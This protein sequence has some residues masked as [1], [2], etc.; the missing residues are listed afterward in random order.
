[1]SGGTWYYE[2]NLIKFYFQIKLKAKDNFQNCLL[3]LIE[4][5]PTAFNLRGFAYDRL[6]ALYQPE[7]QSTNDKGKLFQSNYVSNDV[8]DGSVEIGITFDLRFPSAVYNWEIFY[9]IPILV[10]EFL[11]RHQRFDDAERWLS[12]LFDPTACTGESDKLKNVWQFLPFRDAGDNLEELFTAVAKLV[13]S[14]NL[15][16]TEESAVCAF[17]AQIQ[18]WLASP[19]SPFAVARA[20][21]TAFQWRTIFSYLDSLIARGDQMFRRFTRESVNEAVQYYVLASKLLGPRPQSIRPQNQDPDLSYR[22]IYGK[23]DEFSKAWYTITDAWP[24]QGETANAAST[25]GQTEALSALGMAYFCIP[26]NEKLLGYWDT[27]EDRLFKVRNCMDIDGVARELP[28]FAP[29]IDPELLVRAFAAGLD[30]DTILDDLYA[31]LLPYRF[32]VLL[33][34]AHEICAEV[35]SL[36]GALLAALE[37]KDAEELALLRSSQEI[38]ML[39]LMALIKEQQAKEAEANLDV[40]SQNMAVVLA[41]HNQYQKL[42]GKPAAT[43][44]QNGLPVLTSSSS[45]QAAANLPGEAA[46]L[47]L[48]QYE[49]DQLNSLSEANDYTTAAGISSTVASI[50]HSMPDFVSGNSM[51]LQVKIGGSH[52]G[53]AANAAASFLNM[54]A[55]RASHEATEKGL[56]AS[57][58]RRQDEWVFQ[59]RLALEEMKQINKQIIAAEIRLEIARREEQNHQKQIENARTVDEFMHRKYTNREL[60]SWM[61]GELATVYF[62]A[63]KLANDT[64]KRAEKAFQFEL[65]KE[66]GSFIQFGYWDSLK[67]GLLSGEKLSLDLKR[68][69]MAYLEQNRRELEISKHLS[70]LQLDPL[71]LIGLKETGTCEVSIPEALF[72]I[73][74]PGHYFRRIKSVSI[75]IPCV[76]GPYTSVSCT[77][78]LL[79]HS[80]RKTAQVGSDG[81]PRKTN[82]GG[83]PADDSRFTDSFG[84]IQSIATSH[85]QNDS[86]MFELNFRDERYLPFEGAGAISTW[87]IG[88]PKKFRQFDYDTISDAIIHL[89][90]TA[91]DGGDVLAEKATDN[92]NKALN[93]IISLSR[94]SGLLRLFSLRH[95]FPNEWQRFINEKSTD[96]K[97]EKGRLPFFAQN[98]KL[99]SFRFV[100]K[101]DVTDDTIQVKKNKT[102]GTAPDSESLN[103]TWDQMTEGIY[104]GNLPESFNVSFDE[105]LTLSASGTDDLK[106]L[107]ILVGYTLTER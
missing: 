28:L 85:G 84:S 13:A 81:Y 82:A 55:S 78:R 20:R 50:L 44:D 41:R 47:G 107:Y 91:R 106:E 100:A 75:T 33:Q 26:H 17:D 74:F 10:A 63:Y 15:T 16:Q 12:Y 3:A 62:T 39:N 80:F 71:A 37:K 42:L 40:L 7:V 72:D 105:P 22:D 27:V 36:G 102:R 52:F 88:L 58:Q 38:E 79:K 59:G 46:G 30:I 89:K 69:E 83:I 56:F 90:Y 43:L 95:E 61:L 54:L 8:V 34:K 24:S 18:N 73:D 48:T 68:M 32:S 35:K 96:F 5:P 94:Q 19:F 31:P 98:A 93:E 14:E 29:P 45:L 23:W 67:K 2:D 49:V 64:G 11:T 92:L 60:Y 6:E 4:W 103:V 70:L 21:W 87:R 97:I 65:G 77:L 101:D 57:Y 1:M 9:H 66:D 53:N 25:D 104:L 99:T 86:G 76:A 51:Y